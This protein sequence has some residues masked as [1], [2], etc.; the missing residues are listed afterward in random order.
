MV[1]THKYAKKA[2]RIETSDRR[3]WTYQQPPVLYGVALAIL[4]NC[5]DIVAMRGKDAEQGSNRATEGELRSVA[6]ANIRLGAVFR[7]A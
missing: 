5:F 7:N 2:R 4:K 3:E 1:S 6:D